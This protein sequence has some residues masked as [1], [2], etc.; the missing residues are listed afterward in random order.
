MPLESFSRIFQ[1]K[2]HIFILKVTSHFLHL[3]CYNFK[4]LIAQQVHETTARFYPFVAGGFK[5]YS[6]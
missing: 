4:T 6:I 3:F 2:A 1:K 5:L